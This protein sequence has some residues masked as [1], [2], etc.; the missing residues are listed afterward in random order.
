M[1]AVVSAILSLTAI[2]LW[3]GVAGFS[4]KVCDDAVTPPSVVVS[5]VILSP[6]PPIIG[7]P[8]TF[9][10]QGSTG[11]AVDSGTVDIQ[12]SFSGVEIFATS[13]DL[14]AKT[15][16][17]VAP[18][19]VLVTLV[20]ALPPI[21]PPGEYGLRLTGRDNAGAELMCLEVVFELVLPSSAHVDNAPRVVTGK[22]EEMVA[23]RAAVLPRKVGGII[24]A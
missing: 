9:K 19:E 6:D 24:A 20:E 1:R 2:L 4:W 13:E 11:I 10:V 12:V 22:K 21:A 14:C 7:T 18:G 15:S 17:P 3:Q 23:M 16:C 5:S 8:A